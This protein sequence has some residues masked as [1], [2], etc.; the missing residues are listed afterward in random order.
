MIKRVELNIVLQTPF[1]DFGI[2][3]IDFTVKE[4]KSQNV[5]LQQLTTVKHWI[6]HLMV[7]KREKI[8]ISL[9]NL[10]KF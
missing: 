4:K 3:L 9:S 7:I 8:K 10:F 6:E 1:F 5:H 2:L